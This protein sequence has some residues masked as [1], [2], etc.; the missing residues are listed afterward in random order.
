M[1]LN[2][3]PA[4]LTALADLACASASVAQTKLKRGVT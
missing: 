1:K 3:V 2:R 4:A